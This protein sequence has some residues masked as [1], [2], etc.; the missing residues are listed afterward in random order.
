MITTRHWVLRGTIILILVSAFA[1]AWPIP[2]GNPNASSSSEVL[3]R[4]GTSTEDITYIL[5]IWEGASVKHDAAK[6]LSVLSNM[7]MTLGIGG[8]HTK[9]G[10]SFSSWALSRDIKDAG[11][12]YNFDPG[13]LHYMLGLAV[14]TGL[15]ILVHMNNGRW[16]DC[17]TPNS[18][19]G[20]D[21][22]LLDFIA[23]KPD[24]TMLDSAGESQY[25]HGYGGNF[26]S[27]SRLNKIY[28]GYKQ[29]NTVDSARIIATWANANPS[30][31]AGVSLSS[32]TIYPRTDSDFNPLAI[33]EWKMWMRNTGIYGPGGEYFGQGRVP[34]IH[35]IHAFNRIA[36]QKFSS[37]IS[38]K[39]PATVTPGDPFGEEWQRWRVQMIIHHVSDETLWIASAGIDRN[40]I[41]GHSTPR[42]DEYGLGDAI[43]TATAAN[44]AGGVTLY[45]WDPMDFG[46]VTNA[47][48]GTG[49]NNWGV[50]EVNP[51]ST[52]I[53][54]SYNTL[55][56]LYKDGAKIICPNS[57]ESD[58][59]TKD[60]Y[61]IFDSPSYGNTF[62]NTIQR[63]LSDYGNV[64]RNLQPPSWNPG[65]RIIDFYDIFPSAELTGIDNHREPIGS[66][67]HVVRKSIF[68]HVDG[69]ITFA[70]KLPFVMDGERLNFW[71]SVGIKDGAGIG[72]EVEFQAIINGA[73]KLFGP[74]FYVQQSDWIWNHWTP[75][76]VDVTDWAGQ[77]ISFAL[78]TRGNT[79]YG[80][81]MW[82]S[83][84][85]YLAS[86]DTSS[87][88]AAA[89]NLAFRAPMTASSEDG[90][91]ISQL[92]SNTDS[93]NHGW[94]SISHTLASA[95]EWIVVDLKSKKNISKVVLFP[96]ERL[97]P[98]PG[99]G[100][101]ST[102]EI[103]T[104][105]KSTGPWKAVVK[106]KDY[107][108]PKAGNGEIFTFE[109]TSARFVR[110]YAIELGGV[111][112]ENGYRFQMAKVEIFG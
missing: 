52:D 78:C 99:T 91:P 63:F 59:S 108:H 89:N 40:L 39:P 44:G 64:P 1:L 25:T 51:L 101:P 45:G 22:E 8:T 6:D 23:S 4:A 72:G 66:V 42:L 5:P 83:P 15:P 61:A 110:V 55:L 107:P 96:G 36:K 62:G 65:T 38:V 97:F 77:S 3:P 33:D 75:I 69:T 31:F 74:N 37:W 2:V 47:Y 35:D 94:S 54:K 27:L 71:T 76:M 7:K 67:G 103:Q 9:L 100:F 109:T 95:T 29:R 70:I 18:D 46:E 58:M 34:S 13:N 102:F 73:S 92:S 56:T 60:Q 79:Q 84:A 12:D 98:Y 24:T 85:I 26:F 104:S 80:W 50:L 87:I 41:F 48:R 10:W 30:L 90:G 19:G 111:G 20:W 112:N 32:E 93:N 86:K 21:D 81:T 57:W 16:A 68:S 53:T 14:R 82:G 17:C 106:V 11:S 28:R 43:D 49:K 88:S 105:E